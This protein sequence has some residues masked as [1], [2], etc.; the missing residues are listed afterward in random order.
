MRTGVEEGPW[1]ELASR[2]LLLTGSGS[3]PWA[4]VLE[5]WHCPSLPGT[6]AA[7]LDL[8]SCTE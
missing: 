8:Y 7:T 2:A 1:G 4:P 5:V 3:Q 6:D